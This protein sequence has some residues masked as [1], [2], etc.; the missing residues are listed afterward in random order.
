M[1]F[2]LSFQALDKLKYRK[3][4]EERESILER[5]QLEKLEQ[6]LKVLKS[7]TYLLCSA[8]GG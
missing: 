7:S 3:M 5:D 4:I 2:V 1:C 6:E 8:F